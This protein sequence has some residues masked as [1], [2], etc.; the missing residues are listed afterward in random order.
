[1]N[2]RCDI[3]SNC[4]ISGHILIDMIRVKIIGIDVFKYKPGGKYEGVPLE[5]EIEK[6]LQHIPAASIME[7]TQNKLM[8][9][10]VFYDDTVK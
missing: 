5:T 6:Q 1:M 4:Y 2:D 7:I 10:T 8:G 9:Y 3:L